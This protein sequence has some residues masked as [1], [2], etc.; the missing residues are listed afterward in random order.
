MVKT[1]V[2]DK[3]ME[4]TVN[5][6]DRTPEQQKERDKEIEER[7]TALYKS[8]VANGRGYIFDKSDRKQS[9]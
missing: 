3:G 2:T 4:V 1:F 9:T 5:I 6:P 7:L 8:M